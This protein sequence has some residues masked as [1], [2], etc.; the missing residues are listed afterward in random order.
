MDRIKTVALSDEGFQI[1]AEFEMQ[2]FLQDSFGIYQGPPVTV[3]IRFLK[4]VAGYIRERIW[5]QSQHLSDQADGS[6]VFTATVAG[7]EEIS[8]WVLRWGAGAQVLAPDDLRQTVNRH[9]AAMLTFYQ[10]RP[11]DEGLQE[12]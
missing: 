9:A 12:P 4:S 5:H 3:K 2:A 10:N 7:I 8:H 6:L 1:P 11:P